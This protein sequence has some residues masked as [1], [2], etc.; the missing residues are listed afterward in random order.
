MLMKKSV[1]SSFLVHNLFDKD[2]DRYED[3]VVELIIMF[4]YRNSENWI[5]REDR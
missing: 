2:R 4:Y 5:C 1:F 3:K